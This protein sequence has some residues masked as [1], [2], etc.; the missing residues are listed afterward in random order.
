M[1][2]SVT[3]TSG[4]T[5]IHHKYYLWLESCLCTL[6]LLLW[7]P[8]NHLPRCSHFTDAA[9]D[10][11]LTRLAPAA[12][13]SALCH[14]WLQFRTNRRVLCVTEL[15]ISNTFCFIF[16]SFPAFMHAKK[17]SE[18]CMRVQRWIRTLEIHHNY[19]TSYS[20]VLCSL[21]WNLSFPGVCFSLHLK[22]CFAFFPPT[23]LFLCCFLKLMWE[24]RNKAN[25][26]ARI[27]FL[28]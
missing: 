10:A 17:G 22:K 9:V 28:I 23:L 20:D 6:L 19:R 1:S 4:V 16:T 21:V 14:T 27:P 18:N 7:Q 2:I 5:V 3:F 13:T 8:L 11:W 25:S 12:H 26:R 24:L 15:L